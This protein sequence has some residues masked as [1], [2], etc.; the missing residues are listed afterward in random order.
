MPGGFRLFGPSHLAI[1]A[2][3][4]ASAL[5]LVR[6]A[7]RFPAK[8]DL[9]ARLLGVTLAVNELIWWTYRYSTEGFRFPEGLPLQL[10]DLAVWV[11]VAASL[12]RN[13]YATE[14]SYFAGLAGAAMALLTPDLW[15]PWPSYPSVYYFVAHGMV[16]V[17]VVYVVWGLRVPISRHALWRFFALVNVYAL[18]IGGFN[19]VFG[20]NYLYL[21]HKPVSQTMLDVL[22]PWPVYILLGEVVA[23][24]I[25]AALARFAPRPPKAS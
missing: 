10:C 1:L 7:R 15:A 14:F 16:L 21:C 6:F 25:C 11:T 12:T 24:A 8:S 19:W 20:A 18:L 17:V 9:I 5:T 3:T 23:F 13:R 22:G 2:G 4:M